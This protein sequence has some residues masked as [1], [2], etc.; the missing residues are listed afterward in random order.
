M[1]TLSASTALTSALVLL[2][3]AASSSPS[4]LADVTP[5]TD[6]F[7]IDVV[8]VNGSGCP[9]GSATIA[10]SQD[11]TA[12]T[13]TYS[14]YIAQVGKDISPLESRKNCQLNL[15]V[16]APSGF[17]YAIAQADYRGYAYLQRGATAVQ[18]ASYYFQG[19]SETGTMTHPYSGPLFDDW[20]TTDKT[21]ISSLIYA[22]CGAKRNLNIN[23]EVRINRGSSDPNLSSFISM[24]S[25]DAAINTVYH[26]AWRKC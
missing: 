18:K 19:Q 9:P 12:F 2:A 25:T 17:T 3:A 8:T 21:S 6:K 20:Q 16:N 1:K 7:T 10:V 13:V 15:I 4:A 26:F 14:K 5:P 11:N 24:D 23:T 22:P